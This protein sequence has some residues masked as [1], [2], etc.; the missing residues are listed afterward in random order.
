M[1]K[2]SRR[3]SWGPDGGFHGTIGTMGNPVLGMDRRVMERLANFSDDVTKW[4]GG[5]MVKEELGLNVLA[6][7]VERCCLSLYSIHLGIFSQ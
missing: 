4:Q 6:V 7:V 5:A 2:N 1:Q 3:W